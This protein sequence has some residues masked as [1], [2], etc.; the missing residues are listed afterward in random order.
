MEGKIDVSRANGRQRKKY[1]DDLVGGCGGIVM[2]RRALPS[3][4]GQREIHMHGCQHQL[5][6]HN[7]KKLEVHSAVLLGMAVGS[8][9]AVTKR[10]DWNRGRIGLWGW[11][12]GG[13][14]F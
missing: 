5:T 1:L 3:D 6:L 2:E 9:G 7:K 10:S 14:E 4:S 8:K 11:H 12:R 13:I